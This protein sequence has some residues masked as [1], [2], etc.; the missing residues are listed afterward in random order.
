MDKQKVQIYVLVGI[1]LFSIF[2]LSLTFVMQ[3]SSDN[4][5]V[6]EQIAELQAQADAQ[7]EAQR[8]AEEAL[9]DCGPLPADPTAQPQEVPAEV[10]IVE[11]DVIE[12]EVTTLQEGSGDVAEA[13][14]CIVAHYHG[15]LASDGTVFDSSYE[16]GQPARFPLSGVI[17]GWQE[18][19]PGMREGGIRRLVIPSELAYGPNGQP[20]LIGPNADLVFIVEL[21]EVVE[22]ES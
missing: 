6:N 21:V 18:G 4:A 3:S 8:Q 22:P 5:N 11:E 20:P 14:D 7:A 10:I 17:A 16:R 13:G 19:V 1:M 12:L 9:E 15:T 2:A